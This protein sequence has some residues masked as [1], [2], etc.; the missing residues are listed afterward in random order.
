M[1]DNSAQF[2]DNY[3]VLLG[4]GAHCDSAG[5]R[6]ALVVSNKSGKAPLIR[7]S[8]DSQRVAI[9]A[10]LQLEDTQ[11]MSADTPG[12]EGDIRRNG[13]NLYMYRTTDVHPG[14][15]PLSFGGVMVV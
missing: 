11:D 9:N 6:N 15:Y 14:W 12:T 8:F 7:G 2:P 13:S 10:C 4:F 3:S 5:D 1:V